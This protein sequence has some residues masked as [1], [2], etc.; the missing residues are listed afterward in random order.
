MTIQYKPINYSSLSSETQLTQPGYTV[1]DDNPALNVMTD[2]N[3]IKAYTIESTSTLEFAN[4]KMIACGVRL[5]FV[6]NADNSLVG[7]VTATDLLGE[8]PILYLQQNGGTRENI[9]IKDLMTP[10]AKLK[11][12]ELSNVSKSKVGDIVETMI[13]FGRQHILVV[14][15]QNQF[16]QEYI[17]G[18]FSITHVSRQ[19]GKD[20][21]VSPR[22]NTFAEVENAIAASF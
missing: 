12:L 8:K 14:D 10:R 16:Q 20:I 15:K 13:S 7:L 4:T 5:L 21:D 17:C 3:K 18:L 22:A 1:I 2:L 19:L 6:M 9:P 11:T